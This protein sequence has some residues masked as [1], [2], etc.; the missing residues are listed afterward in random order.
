MIL[1]NSLD[2]LTIN[3]NKKTN[4]LNQLYFYQVQNVC[5]CYE[6]YYCV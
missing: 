6:V 3:Q 5:F 2:S 4:I 1:M